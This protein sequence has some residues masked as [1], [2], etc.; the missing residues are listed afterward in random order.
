M[1]VSCFDQRVALVLPA[2]LDCWYMFI[3]PSVHTV[4]RCLCPLCED[5][6]SQARIVALTQCMPVAVFLHLVDALVRPFLLSLSGMLPSLF[7]SEWVL[8]PLPSLPKPGGM[9]YGHLSLRCLFLQMCQCVAKNVDEVAA[10]RCSSVDARTMIQTI[11]FGGEDIYSRM[12]TRKRMLWR[13]RIRCRVGFRLS[14]VRMQAQIESI[15]GTDIVLQR[16]R[17][18]IEDLNS[19]RD[20]S[21]TPEGLCKFACNVGM[22]ERMLHLA[23]RFSDECYLAFASRHYIGELICLLEHVLK[24]ERE[25]RLAVAMALHARLGGGSELAALGGDL[26]PLCIPSIMSPPIGTW[27]QLLDGL[28]R[29]ASGAGR[30][31]P[32]QGMRLLPGGGEGP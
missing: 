2:G 31:L 4:G 24:T 21:Y 14:I 25:R 6:F 30:A 11:V 23:E 16:L 27:A 10:G 15:R 7:P 8:H 22:A 3:F 12:L 26:L 9:P 18:Q 28:T 13:G 19:H 29:T 17:S 20:V 32:V 1:R 5:R